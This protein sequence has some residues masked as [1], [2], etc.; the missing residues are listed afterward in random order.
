VLNLG[1]ESKFLSF[2]SLFLMLLTKNATFLF[3]DSKKEGRPVS[4]REKE[5]V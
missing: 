2:V 3:G 1:R 4:E 5:S